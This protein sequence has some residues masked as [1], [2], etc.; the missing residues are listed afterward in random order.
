MGVRGSILVAV[1]GECRPFWAGFLTC[2]ALLPGLW[3]E[4]VQ[5]R[6]R[7]RELADRE[8]EAVLSEKAESAR[9]IPERSGVEADN[10]SRLHDPD[11]DMPAAPPDDPES[12]KLMRWVDGKPGGALWA[13]T[14]QS[15]PAEQ[16][17]FCK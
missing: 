5:E 11:A 7:Y 13:R 1:G 9:W 8:A 14:G 17:L 6:T 12:A 2:A 16:L 3:G 15:S 10:R 4:E